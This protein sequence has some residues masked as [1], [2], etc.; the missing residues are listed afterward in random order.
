MYV[1]N[2]ASSPS[3]AFRPM[4][5]VASDLA[6]R[7]AQAEELPEALVVHFGHAENVGDGEHGEGLRVG[8]DE[9]A[10]AVRDELVDLLIGRPP[11]E[12]LVL[13]EALG[14]E[15]AHH[16]GALLGVHGWVHGHHVLVHGQLVPMAVDD[17]SDV[18]ALEWDG[19]R[20]ERADHRVAGR[21]GLGV[22]V[23]L[24]CLLVARDRH[25]AEVV[26]REHGALRPQV[27]E[28]GVGVLHQ[29]LVTEE[30]DRLPV[31][32]R[33]LPSPGRPRAEPVAALCT[34]SAVFWRMLSIGLRM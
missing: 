34:R 5:A 28:V 19:K 2:Q 4:S 9:L 30:V 3:S 31:A 27:V 29:G 32:Q 33:G 26:G 18:V 23:D 11:H 24:Q 7:G 13:L 12:L 25:H 20:R 1:A 6:R 14:R 15:Q 22:E 16:Q 21:E 8:A 17:R 10:V